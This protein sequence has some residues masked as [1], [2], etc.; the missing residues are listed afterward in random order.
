M[1]NCFVATD[2]NVLVL[3]RFVVEKNRMVDDV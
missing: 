3:E 1:L 2:L